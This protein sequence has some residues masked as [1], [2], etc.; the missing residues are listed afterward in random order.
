M[1]L[2]ELQLSL[3]VVLPVA[4]TIWMVWSFIGFVDNRVLPLV[5]SYYNPLT[6]VDFNIRGVGVV[7]FLLFTTLMGAI[8]K[9]L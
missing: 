2:E 3:V 9:G 1:L 6:Y 8:T 5:P 4:L 7:I